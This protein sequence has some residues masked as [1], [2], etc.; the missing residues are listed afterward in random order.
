LSAGLA[1]N[2][3]AHIATIAATKF[4]VDSSASDHN[5]TELVMTAASPLI[6]TVRTAVT[7]ESHKNRSK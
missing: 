5:P 4:T 3:I 1:D 7:I 6:V 2:R